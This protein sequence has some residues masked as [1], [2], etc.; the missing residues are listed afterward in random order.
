MKGG[1]NAIMYKSVALIPARAG[2][3]GLKDKNVQLL[4]GRPLIEWTLE[5]AR[6][7]QSI[8]RTVVSTNDVKVR[9]ICSDH[10]CEVL[11]RPDALSTSAAGAEDVIAHFLETGV[12]EDVIVY[13]QPTSPLRTSTDIDSCVALL[14][15]SGADAVVSLVRASEKPEWMFRVNRDGSLRPLLDPTDAHTRQELETT[16]MLNGAIYAYRTTSLRRSTRLV[17]LRVLGYEMPREQSI[18]IDDASDLVAAEM[19]L[20][21]FHES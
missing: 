1:S 5:A 9:R 16:Y 6:N 7:S 10:T 8:N 20:S 15:T 4:A 2:S 21:L 17:D 3:V 14:G 19:Y 18:D 11:D 12:S 13:L